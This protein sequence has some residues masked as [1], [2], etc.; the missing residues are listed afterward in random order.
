MTEFD[1]K[2]LRQLFGEVDD[3]VAERVGEHLL[4]VGGAALIFAGMPRGTEDVDVLSRLSSRSLLRAI[5]VVG[6]RHELPHDWINDN[7]AG[8]S[9][10]DLSVCERRL[11]FSGRNIQVFRPDLSYLLALK[12]RS[13][14][15]KDRSDALWLE[16]QGWPQNERG[17]AQSDQT[18]LPRYAHPRIHGRVRGNCGRGMK[19]CEDS[20]WREACL[21]VDQAAS[22]LESTRRSVDPR[23]WKAR[24]SVGRGCP[25]LAGRNRRPR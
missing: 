9:F 12:L 25:G 10:L 24:E 15:E 11:V 23:V 7:I 22:L 3:E 5:R 8:V 17:T 14:R 1:R 6:E 21:R 19:R 13:A 4:V 20:R 18:G 16:G 2:F